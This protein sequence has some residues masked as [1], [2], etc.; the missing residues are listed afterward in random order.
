MRYPAN[1]KPSRASF[2]IL[3]PLLTLIVCVTLIAAPM[4]IT[5]MDLRSIAHPGLGVMFHSHIAKYTVH[6]S[7][8]FAYSLMVA[9][10]R[11]SHAIQAI[12]LPAIAIELPLDRCMPTW[13]MTWTPFHMSVEMWRALIDPIY[14]LPFAWFGGLGIDAL[15]KRRTLRWPILLI[16]TLLG[17]FF[18]FITCGLIFGLS[19]EDH[20]GGAWIFCGFTFWDILYCVFP[21][22]WIRQGRASRRS[23]SQAAVDHSEPQPTLPQP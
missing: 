22:A 6:R 19:A 11:S 7:Q 10:T 21:A 17:A 20:K 16:G 18:I 9:A 2:A 23:T 13:P 14:C 12:T 15:L 4:T 5:Y 3:L 1:V 8:F